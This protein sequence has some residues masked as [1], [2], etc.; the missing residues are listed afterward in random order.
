M[1]KPENLKVGDMFRVIVEDCVFESG[2]IV[3]L[4][5]DDGTDWPYFWDAHKSD[6]H[7]INFSD[8]EPHQK[9]VRDVQVDDVV[10]G[11][12]NGFEYMV[13]ERGQRTV[14]LTYYDNFKKSKDNYTF[15]ELEQYFTLKDAP[16]VDDNIV[17][18]MNEI[19]ERLGVDVSKLKI[20]KE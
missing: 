8:L 9:T 2:E 4:K 6:W 13:L 7:C 3:T 10:I 20:K 17:L 16:E 18:T 19:A 5:E 11:K 1:E 15:D 14:L 12:L